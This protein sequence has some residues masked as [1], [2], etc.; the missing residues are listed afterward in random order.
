[1][2]IDLEAGHWRLDTAT[3]GQENRILL[4]VFLMPRAF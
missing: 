1:M 3:D 4:A 2:E